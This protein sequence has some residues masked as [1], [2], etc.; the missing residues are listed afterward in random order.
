MQQNRTIITLCDS[1]SMEKLIMQNAPVWKIFENVHSKLKLSSMSVFPSI[2]ISRQWS[3]VINP[4]PP[5]PG[6]SGLNNR[7][8]IEA[9]TSCCSFE[10]VGE[11][12]KKALHRF[13][14]RRHLHMLSYCVP[15]CE[16]SNSEQHI[17]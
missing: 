7:L 1:L 9:W 10:K 6:L 11:N 12:W 5:E 3:K 15:T 13:S 17:Q 16:H 2:T 8:Y 14:A 4:E